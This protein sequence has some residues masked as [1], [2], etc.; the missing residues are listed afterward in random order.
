MVRSEISGSLWLN[1]GNLFLAL[2]RSTNIPLCKIYF[3]PT[4]PLL[5]SIVEIQILKEKLDLSETAMSTVITTTTQMS[6][7]LIVDGALYSKKYYQTIELLY[8]TV[9]NIFIKRSNRFDVHTLADSERNSIVVFWFETSL[10]TRQVINYS[11]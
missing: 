8:R 11:V 2:T 9:D 3:H 7:V 6:N 4:F 1:S 10:V 5:P